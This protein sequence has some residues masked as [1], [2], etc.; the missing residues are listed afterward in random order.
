MLS[1]VT[2]KKIEQLLNKFAAQVPCLNITELEGLLYALVITPELIP[3]SEWIPIIFDEEVPECDSKDLLQQL[4]NEFIHAYNHYNTLYL[5]GNLH[6]P[7]NPETLTPDLVDTLLDW[8]FGFWQGLQLRLEFWNSGIFAKKMNLEEDP[9]IEMLKVIKFI[10]DTEYEDS[11]F[12]NN[13]LQDKPVELD[14]DAFYASTINEFL[15][16]LPDMVRMIQQFADVIKKTNGQMVKQTQVQSKKIG[17][18]DPCP[19]GSGNK[20]KKCCGM[21]GVLEA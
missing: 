21:G 18:N 1:T 11:E 2:K 5:K 14:V 10:S 16:M 19:C 20:Y 9:I 4:V 17:R 8:N 6:F 12:F 15:K 7:Y 13:I 3:P